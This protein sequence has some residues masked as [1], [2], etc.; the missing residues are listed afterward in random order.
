MEKA[1]AAINKLKSLNLETTDYLN[2]L[3]IVKGIG[4]NFPAIS[5]RL[6]AGQSIYRARFHGENDRFYF[7]QD[8]KYKTDVH[9]VKNPGR[10]NP[11]I[12][13]AFYGSISTETIK[14]GFLISAQEGSN[15]IRNGK[16]GIE[17]LTIGKWVLKR[18]MYVPIMLDTVNYRFQS[19]SIDKMYQDFIKIIKEHKSSEEFKKIISFVAGE[20]AKPV[21]K[22]N[23]HEYKISAAISER[24]LDKGSCGIIY[25]SVQTKYQGY[26][27]VLSPYVVDENLLLDQVII[28]QQHVDGDNI[29]FPQFEHAELVYP[30]DRQPLIYNQLDDSYKAGF[31]KPLP[32][33]EH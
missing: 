11:A 23:E 21:K 7:D 5:M 25:P 24:L 18:D 22:G 33:I 6:R 28:A 2:I 30:F 3:E 32:N 8:L 26:N 10:A 12:S 16:N 4:K 14:D 27:I 1:I 13:T 15:L 29:L 19:E 31:K 20:F 9:N 17:T